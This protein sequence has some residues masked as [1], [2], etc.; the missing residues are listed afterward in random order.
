MVLLEVDVEAIR[1]LLAQVKKE[2]SD[3]FPPSA[4]AGFGILKALSEADI[5]VPEL[6]E[7]HEAQDR[8][9][10]A[11]LAVTQL[12]IELDNLKT[13]N[14]ALARSTPAPVPSGTS[15]VE[16]FEK[17]EL[18]SGNRD[19]LRT[20]VAKLRTRCA[21]ITDTQAKLRYAFNA[22]S[23][24]AAAQILP[25]VK[26]DKVDLVDLAALIN[27]LENAFGNPNRVRDAENRLF[28]I[29]QGN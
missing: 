12:R 29:N 26:D 17:I 22:L 6:P 27:I 28:T 4:H 23:G 1:I 8:A 25:Y 18:Y 5:V 14:L 24:P 7:L 2:P 9:H 20:F 3:S 15:N 19:E 10:V 11:E 16:K 13:V 21:A